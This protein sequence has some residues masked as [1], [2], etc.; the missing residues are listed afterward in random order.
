MSAPTSPNRKRSAHWTED[1]TALLVDLLLRHKDTGRTSDNGFKPEVWKEAAGMLQRTVVLGG[2]KTAEACKGR[3]QRL[4]R[5]FKAVRE[6]EII[7]GF[8]FDRST[9]K[10][11]ASAEI[12]ASQTKTD[13]QRLQKVHLPMY[14][15]V[16]ILCSGEYSNS[17]RGRVKPRSSANSVS[18]SSLLAMSTGSS[19]APSQVHTQGSGEMATQQIPSAM[20]QHDH[21]RLPNGAPLLTHMASDMQGQAAL[22][23][24]LVMGEL[25]QAGIA[26]GMMQ[27]GTGDE[28]ADGEYNAAV[29]TMP[30]GSQQFFT[31]SSGS[32]R[33]YFDP[34]FLT[35]QSASSNSRP[36]P[37]HIAIPTVHPVPTTHA[38]TAPAHSAHDPSAAPNHPGT[39]P[40]SEQSSPIK[41]PRTSISSTRAPAA[42]DLA[43]PMAL[44]TNASTSSSSS[45]TNPPG[46]TRSPEFTHSSSSTNLIDPTLLSPTTTTHLFASGAGSTSFKNQQNH[47]HHHHQPQNQTQPPQQLQASYFPST[48]TS[49]SPTVLAAEIA[50]AGLNEAQRRTQAL[51]RLQKETHL[52]DE[53]VVQ[54]M[55]EFERNVATADTYLAIEGSREG[56]RRLWLGGLLRRRK[57]STG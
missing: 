15:S 56:L 22:G 52:T 3:W 42:R 8:R 9:W 40:A 25:T 23:S 10:L 44:P 39:Q 33:H 6:M 50:A 43:Y 28:D 30:D 35:T 26:D 29:Y 14:D 49:P 45:T 5:D 36:H 4:Q 1:D 54:I 34:S 32:K 41:R 12:W 31:M 53:E 24:Q 7:P 27:W 55:E 20:Q 19:S 17:V 18:E 11:E 51:V 37:Q 13:Q 21:A 38:L 2:P 46:P 16:S 48:T 57:T 47:H